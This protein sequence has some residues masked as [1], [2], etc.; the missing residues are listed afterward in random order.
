MNGVKSKSKLREW[1]RRYIPAEVLGTIT[2]LVP[3]WVAYGHTHSFVA[4]AAAGWVGEGVGFYGYFIVAELLSG[5]SRHKHHSFFKRA[6]L[7]VA[8]AGT[9]LLVEFAP[10][11]VLDNFIIRPFLMFLIPHYVHPYALGFLAG[12]FSADIIFY[13]L[14]IMGYEAR[15]RWLG[16]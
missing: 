8:A 15:K 10:A 5:A 9:N 7:A 6:A 4:G 1:L 2:A 3:A 14:A 11:E 16:R 13:T 12:K